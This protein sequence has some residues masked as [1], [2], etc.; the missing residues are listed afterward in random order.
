MATFQKDGFATPFGRN[1][2]LRSTKGV[3][4]ISRTLARASVPAFIIDGF[5]GQKVL[6]PGTVLATIT[7]GP[8]IGKVGPFQ[9]AGVDEV[10]T[11]TG[12]GTISGGTFIVTIMG[13]A[14]A[15]IAW[16]ATAAQ[17]QTALRLAVSID[18]NRTVVEKA[19]ADGITVTG[20][21]I[22]STPFVVT[23]NG[24][25]AADVAQ[26]TVNVAALTGTA[27]AITP[28]TGTAGVAGATDGREVLANIVG[29]N[30]TF[31]PWQLMDRDVEVAVIF[32]ADVVQ[33]Q[34]IV[35]NA[36]GSSVALDNTTA[37]AMFGTKTLDIRFAV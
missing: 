4:T 37:A 23:Y 19:L 3:K 16:N 17:V 32:E 28:T 20:G 6:Q 8:D 34:C 33:A 26:M 24:E 13:S 12:G 36:S 21:P 10:Q 22:A 18:P 35:L 5:P 29:L 11:L 14:T 30:K 1:E 27:P 9:T 2:F 25:T 7:S 15:A 31:L